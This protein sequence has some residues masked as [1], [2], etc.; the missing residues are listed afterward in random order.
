MRYLVSI[1]TAMMFFIWILPLGVFIKLSQERTV[2]DGQRAMCMCHA[3]VIKEKSNGSGKPILVH[4]SGSNKEAASSGGGVNQF[5][6]YLT[7]NS[8]NDQISKHFES[9]EHF[10]SLLLVRNIEHVPKA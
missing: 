5:L 2:C 3:M 7:I 1:L 9:P 4:N 6:A 8:M 10:S